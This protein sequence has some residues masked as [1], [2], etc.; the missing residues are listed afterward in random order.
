MLTILIEE[1]ATYRI[2]IPA[3]SV[4]EKDV[5]TGEETGALNA[6]I[7]RTFTVKKDGELELKMIYPT[8]I[9]T[10]GTA[11]VLETYLNGS[12][13]GINLDTKKHVK[14]V[15][16]AEGED[17]MTLDAI[18]STNQLAFKPTSVLK[19][20]TTYTLTYTY[21]ADNNVIITVIDNNVTYAVT[22]SKVFTFKT[23]S[24][25]GTEPQ[26]VS[27][28]PREGAKLDAS[29][30]YSSGTI[31][32]T[33]DQ[34]VDLEPYSTVNAT[35]I[36]GSEATADGVT[37]APEGTGNTLTVGDDGK[38][39]SFDYTADGLKYDLYYEVVIP[40]NTVV[41][42]GGTPNSEPITLHFK[43]GKNPNATEV[44]AETF[45]PHTWDFCKFG[46]NEEGTTS[47]NI[48]N[49][50]G[51]GNSSKINNL[52]RG[53]GDG[54]TIYTSDSQTGY[55]WDQGND[56]YFNYKNG[57]YEKP[58]E[59]EGIRISL[60]KSTSNR[61]ELRNITSKD[62]D[63][64]NAD[65]SD[66][67]V[68]RM[69]GNTHYMTL[70]N[71]PAGKL[72][73][74]VN[75]PYV[76]INSPNATFVESDNYTL[77]NNNTLL[78]TSGT[79]KVVINVTEAGDVSFC[80]KNFNCEKIGV[81][82][83]YKSFND[84]DGKGYSTEWRDHTERYDLTNCFTDYSVTAEAVT[85]YSKTSDD[86]TGTLTLFPVE[87]ADAETPV[88]VTCT[89]TG[90]TEVPLFATDVNTAT[91]TI[92]GTNYLEG[93]TGTTSI[94]AP[95]G[96]Y[97]MTT[98][99]YNTDSE[100]NIADGAKL[101]T[102]DLGFYKV[103]KDNFNTVGVNKAYLRLPASASSAKGFMFIYDD[104][105]TTMIENTRISS[106][107]GASEV[108]NLQG[109]RVAKPERGIYIKNGKKFYVK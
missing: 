26:L 107:Q 33:F 97:I 70:S 36:N 76:G 57:N 21:N 20:N 63:T 93:N 7:V 55:G 90:A 24:A 34:T 16:S 54:Y 82:P 11:I 13:S 38:T 64:K 22:H 1:G 79:R 45:Y 31:S 25:S 104:S 101:N 75:S 94:Y 91:T 59:F 18:I 74:V 30:T 106:E 15:L 41:G 67:W 85:A 108:F 46:K 32:F 65:G 35:P 56:V 88:I 62:T 98:K 39:V 49:Y 96:S 23:G 48:K 92:E 9:A 99:F 14:C 6:E 100:G 52:K 87:V 10:V 68:F 69:N 72:Y 43:M 8:E 77:S 86:G 19:P 50:F 105:E 84:W 71:V 53:N 3:G 42:A 80:V 83:T 28:T 12:T 78:K 73:M 29:T 103:V 40:V 81:T 37:R 66:K 5:E 27:T 102:G 95:K 58:D 109:Q 61:F 44:N 60:V 17:P 2:T 4:K 89:T 51:H 47:Y